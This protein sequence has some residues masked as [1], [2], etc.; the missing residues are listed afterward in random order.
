MQD[1]R[2]LV[3][4]H[5]PLRD[6]P[7]L[8]SAS[9]ISLPSSRF[10]Q[11]HIQPAGTP[12]TVP[13][14]WRVGYSRPHQKVL[15]ETPST[16]RVSRYLFRLTPPFYA[17]PPTPHHPSSL[18]YSKTFVQYALSGVMKPCVYLQKSCY[19]NSAAKVDLT[20]I[21]LLLLH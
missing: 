9:V 15:S 4:F 1:G 11:R 16:A 20:H 12:G 3:N 8:H 18:L 2:S 19:A 5:P 21:F 13:P 17:K 10:V 14:S 7:E 6:F